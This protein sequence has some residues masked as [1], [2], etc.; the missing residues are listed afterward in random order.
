M[1]GQEGA[2]ATTYFSAFDAMLSSTSGFR[3]ETRSRR[4]PRNEVNA[5]L[6]FLY[7]QLAHDTRSALETVGLDPSAGYLHTLRPGRRSFA[8]DLMEE[9]RAP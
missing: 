9:L 6:S 3:F 8:L 1:R 2:A 5:V 7:T 4:P